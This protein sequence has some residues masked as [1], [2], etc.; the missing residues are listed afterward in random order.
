PSQPLGVDG[1]GPVRGAEVRATVLSQKLV[2]ITGPP[3]LQYHQP[4]AQQRLRELV[5]HALRPGTTQPDSS[6]G[7]EPLLGQGIPL[8]N[9]AVQ[10]RQ[11]QRR[12]GAVAGHVMG[13]E[14]SGLG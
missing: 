4:A 10:V 14:L 3:G 11:P 9:G 5:Y 12:G 2:V 7:C 8:L 13:V 6:L 1:A